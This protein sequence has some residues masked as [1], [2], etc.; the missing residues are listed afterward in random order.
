[1]LRLYDTASREVRPLAPGRDG[2]IGLYVC[3]PTV[4]APPHVGHGRFNL[5]YDV[6]RRYLRH[7]G[8]DVV[9][10]SNVTDV[11]D[12][13]IQR[14]ERESREPAEVAAEAEEQWWRAMDLLGVGRPDEIPHATAYIPQM[15]ELI[16]GLVSTGTAYLAADGVY[17]SVAAVPG[18][19]LLPHQDPDEL[20][21]GARVEAGEAKRAPADF[22][23]WKA[24][25]PG[26]PC[27]ESPFGPGR[28]GWHTECVAM[29][30]ELLGEG[31]SLH[32]GGQD[33]IFPHHE[34][35]R[36]QAVAIGREFA[37]HW[38]H[39]GMVVAGGEKMS[40]SI[41]NIVSLEDLLGTTDARA[42][43]LLVLQSHYRSPL[44]VRPE[45]LED[46][47][48]ALERVDSLA[49]RLDDACAGSAAGAPAAGG[50]GSVG[51]SAGTSGAARP[52][53]LHGEAD[54]LGGAF[55]SAMDDDLDTPRALALV[56]SEGV[57]RAN[58]LFDAGDTPGALALGQRSID[59]L[60]ALGLAVTTADQAPPEIVALSEQREAARSA[61]DWPSADA[62]RAELERAGWQV[63]DTASGPKLRRRA[64]G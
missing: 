13:I 56:L 6:L 22:A 29:S 12:K 64:S 38:M 3:G 30:L 28:P 18:Y 40:K 17:L 60:G 26:E 33:L 57:R 63:E 21:A 11:D 35:E 37:R 25:K 43:R 19:G 27:W 49:R 44:E 47:A 14:A 46:A 16:S 9:Y 31:F 23:L 54:A 5:V 48:R 24:A 58:S 15:V 34:N 7:R 41:G 1:M 53:P 32:G 61:R 20:R 55:E 36:A 59:L 4:Y 42:Y 50:T 39:N 8:A 2:R 52:E 51:P 62:L 10:V 45:L